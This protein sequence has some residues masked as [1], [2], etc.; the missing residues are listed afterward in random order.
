MPAVSNSSPLIVLAAIGR[1][2]LLPRLYG[3]VVVPP[4]VWQEVVVAGS[5]RAGATVLPRLTWQRRE[6]VPSD[7]ASP[8]SL[9]SLDQ[10]EAEAIRLVLTF[11]RSVPILLD[12]LPARRAA[13]R[14]GLSVAGTVGVLLLAKRTGRIPAVGSL[15]REARAAGLFLSDAAVERSLILAGEL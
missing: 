14:L 9:A 12:D 8:R 6:P 1:L 3:Q 4:T 11:P 13:E 10:G 5:G 7:V 15:L 2:E